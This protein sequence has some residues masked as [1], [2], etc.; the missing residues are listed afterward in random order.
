MNKIKFLLKIYSFERHSCDFGQVNYAMVWILVPSKVQML[1]PSPQW[2]DIKRW[3]LWEVTRS[4]RLGPYNEISTPQ[5]TLFNP[6]T[7]WGHSNKVPSPETL[8][9][10]ALILDLPTS[11]TMRNVCC[12]Q[13]TQFMVFFN[14]HPKWLSDYVSLSVKWHNN[15]SPPAQSIAKIRFC[16]WCSCQRVRQRANSQ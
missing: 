8:S 15:K 12:F 13:A 10:K 6:S 1:K 5:E 7:R 14:S 11:R 2:D 9:A 3:C 4:W 16:T